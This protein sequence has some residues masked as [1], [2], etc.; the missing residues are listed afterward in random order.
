MKDIKKSLN[1]IL[2]RSRIFKVHDTMDAFDQLQQSPAVEQQGTIK[3]CYSYDIRD[4]ETFKQTFIVEEK[5][6][7]YR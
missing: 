7:K 4:S 3:G 6:K 5:I 1:A 2:L